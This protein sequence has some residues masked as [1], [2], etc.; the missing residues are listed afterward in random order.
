MATHVLVPVDGSPAARKALKYAIEQ[1]SDGT[2]TLLYVMDPMIEF[3]RQQAYPGFRLDDEFKNERE[4]GQHVLESLLET[5]PDG[6]SVETELEAGRPAETIVRY[7]DD[8]DVDQIVIGS[9]GK[10][11]VAR[12][13]LGSVAETIV[14]RSVVPVTVVRP[15]A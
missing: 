15:T 14:R 9:H 11:G 8:H 13:L 6:M 2:L 7:A 5:V 10:R 4:K 3:S 12:F 1:L